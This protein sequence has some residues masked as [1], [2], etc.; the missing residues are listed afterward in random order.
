VLRRH[1]R[2]VLTR[3]D[4][5][6]VRPEIVD[7]TS[8]FN[9]GAIDDEGTTRLLLRVQTRGRRTHLLEAASDDGVSF[10]VRPEIVRVEGLDAVGSTVHHVYDPR[11]TRIDGVVHAVVALDLDDGCRLGVARWTVPS[12]LELR[13]LVSD[14]DE[15]NGVLFPERVGGRWMMLS[16]PNRPVVEG[17]ATTGDEIVL[18]ASDDLCRFERIG[19]VMSGRRHYWDEL[20]G[21][22]P[23]PV[24]TR[25]GWLLVYHGVATHL[26]SAWIY[27][28]GA[29][30]LDLEDPTRVLAGRATTCSSPARPGRWSARCRMSCSRPA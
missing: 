8:V 25:E 21:A 9:P 10:A 3:E 30:L 24:K 27:Q 23:P 26:A 22:G 16:R 15:R 2:P 19:P 28:A 20:I 29:A 1:P 13:G 7:A 17:A 4:V 18:A 5:P 11:L 6:D 12:R 14:E